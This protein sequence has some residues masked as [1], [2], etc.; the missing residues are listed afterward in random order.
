MC[1][2]PNAKSLPQ[3][4]GGL[5][6][7]RRRRP[8]CSRGAAMHG[9][10]RLSS[11][12]TADPLGHPPQRAPGRMP[13]PPSNSRSR[14]PL[15]LPTRFLCRPQ[16]SGCSPDGLPGCGSAPA[17][18]V[19]T[20]S[21]RGGERCSWWISTPPTNVSLRTVHAGDMDGSGVARQG[22]LVPHNLELAPGEAAPA[23]Q[24]AA[25]FAEPGLPS[26]PSVRTAGRWEAVPAYLQGDGEPAFRELLALYAGN[27]SKKEKR[28]RMLATLACRSAVKQGDR[29]PE[30]MLVQILNELDGLERPFS[31][32]HGRPAILE[33][34]EKE[35]AKWF[36]RT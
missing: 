29:I 26:S 23:G 32:P 4:A 2:R 22:L 20:G 5:Y 27:L 18:S 8:P 21:W 17:S 31:C 6:P 11:A 1:I 16:R 33:I 15:F 35:V 9:L 30:T 36:K 24:H 13:S 7:D 3:G 28:E 10:R 34:A 25:A 12:G 19:I 14:G